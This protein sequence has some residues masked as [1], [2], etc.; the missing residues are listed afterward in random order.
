MADL[1]TVLEID[2]RDEQFKKAQAELDS[3]MSKLQDA[4]KLTGMI[5][6]SGAVAKVGGPKTQMDDFGKSLKEATKATVGFNASLTKTAS[7]IVFDSGK[8]LVSAFTSITKTILGTGGLLAGLTS[9]ATFAGLVRTAASTQ[10]RAYI[11]NIYGINPN[12]ITRLGSTYGQLGDVGGILHALEQERENPASRLISQGLGMTPGQAQETNA[13]DLMDRLFD[14]MEGFIKSPYPINQQMAE[15]MGFGEIPGVVEIMKRMRNNPEL[16]QNARTQSQEYQEA[17]QLKNPK[18]W[19]NFASQMGLRSLRLETTFQNAFEGLLDPIL[20]LMDTLRAKFMEGATGGLTGVIDRVRI[21]LEQFSSAMSSGNW[22]S[23]WAEMKRDASD[24]WEFIK[25]L[26][27]KAWEAIGESFSEAFPSVT[28]GFDEFLESLKSLSVSMSEIAMSFK[29][30]RQFVDAMM[31]PLETIK[32]IKDIGGAVSED[33]GNAV[34]K[35]HEWKREHGIPTIKPEDIRTGAGGAWEYAKGVAEK[36]GLDENIFKKMLFRES[37]GNPNAV[38][39]KGALGYGQL[40]PGTAKELGVTD[41][42]DYQQN[43]LASGKYLRQNLDEFGSYDLALAAYN[44][45]PGAVKKYGRTIPPY[46]ETQNYVAAILGDKSNANGVKTKSSYRKTDPTSDFTSA[47]MSA[48]MQRNAPG[49]AMDRSIRI[50]I[51]N[52][53]S[54]ADPTI[55]GARMYGNS[56]SSGK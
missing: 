30:V 21:A 42:F 37:G 7:S 15:A 1:T 51:N 36:L 35:F 5:G 45:G 48:A 19:Q 53:H 31:H 11:S 56:Y 2:V 47:N 32:A 24:A 26:A 22:D 10:H 33:A 14:R 49:W 46:E 12:D 17:T 25:P 39:P 52:K 27:R 8:K 20:K 54:S 40:M 28:K 23:F 29:D 16:L 6:K 43:I 13:I 50:D 44:A 3:F 9:M 18:A 38:S 41:P 34:D 4:S 55:Q